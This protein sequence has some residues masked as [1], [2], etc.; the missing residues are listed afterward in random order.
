[1]SSTLTIEKKYISMQTALSTFVGM[2]MA[3]PF[4][5]A[6]GALPSASAAQDQSSSAQ[7][8]V[9][10]LAKFA[11]AYNASASSTKVA[12]DGTATCSEASVST[13]P[14]V[15]GD[16]E[17]AGGG[18]GG[19]WGAGGGTAAK[20]WSGGGKVA[21]AASVKP[22]DKIAS[23]VNSHNTYTSMIYNSSSV[24]NTNSNNTVGS[25][26]TTSTDLSLKVEDSKGLM[27]GMGVSN[28]PKASLVATNDSFNED[29][30]NTKTETEIV[31]DSFNKETNLTVTKTEDSYNIKNETEDSF[32]SKVETEDSFNSKVENETEDSYNTK[33][34]TEI[35]DSNNTTTNETTIEVED[36]EVDIEVEQENPPHP[37]N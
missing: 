33:T 36:V 6:A 12:A 37:L 4:V 29:S 32:N 11:T 18:G 28:D 1:M 9:A 13:G 23:M 10:D 14:A 3:V 35:E 31:N 26:N 34:E 27:V 17:A 25:N 2:M 22:L 24:T 20:P 7:V 21:G 30:Y 19:G 8:S 15:L 5:F 16:S